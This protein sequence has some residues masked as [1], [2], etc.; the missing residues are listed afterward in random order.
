[1]GITSVTLK[2]MQSCA[3]ETLVFFVQEM[4]D[5]PF[6]TEDVDIIFAPR[7]EISARFKAF[8]EQYA[9]ERLRSLTDNHLEAL[10]TTL[11]GN[12]II[13][14]DR[15]AALLRRNY[16]IGRD[17]LRR[18]V[19]HE[20]MHIHCAKTEVDGEHFIDIYG[21]GHTHDL[22]PDDKIYDGQV[23]AGYTVWCEFIAEYFATVKS[24]PQKNRFITIA[25]K[26]LD[27]LKDITV[28]EE[29][30]KYSFSFLS[31]YILSCADAPEAIK[32]L[33]G[34]SDGSPNG[35]AATQALQDCL[36]YLHDHVQSKQPCKISEDF[37]HTLG[38]LYLMFVI[39]NSVYLGVVDLT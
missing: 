4:P 15:S 34:I 25:E 13:G 39:R 5:V 24:S 18:I 14:R 3:N 32:K 9:P 26:L 10:E 36:A 11:Y 35:E 20:L 12:A 8:A 28:A 37:I 31:A 1:M 23:N 21:S 33:G 19:F 22:H 7:S 6:R 27:L 16:N 38:C 17:N 29:G 30:A 2:E